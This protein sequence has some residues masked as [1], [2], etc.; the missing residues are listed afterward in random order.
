MYPLNAFQGTPVKVDHCLC[1]TDTAEGATPCNAANC[2]MT[3]GACMACPGGD[4]T[5]PD[6]DQFCQA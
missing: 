1:N 4:L 5:N 2:F 3:N 6:A